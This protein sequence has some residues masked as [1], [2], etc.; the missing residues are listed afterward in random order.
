ML[1]IDPVLADRFSKELDEAVFPPLRIRVGTT[2]DLGTIVRLENL[3]T[4]AEKAA[5][6]GGS[7]RGMR[8]SPPGSPGFRVARWFR[9]PSW[10][11][12]GSSG[13]GIRLHPAP[14]RTYP[15]TPG[16]SSAYRFLRA[17]VDLHLPGQPTAPFPMALIRN[18]SYES[19]FLRSGLWRS[20]VRFLD[21]KSRNLSF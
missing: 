6:A 2:R 8:P 7:P 21:S 1:K 20:G 18:G 5:A 13:G 19:A 4:P 10:S 15:P 11:P 9:D 3:E 14:S 17:R 16:R 12:P